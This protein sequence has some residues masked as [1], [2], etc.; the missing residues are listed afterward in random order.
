MIATLDMRRTYRVGKFNGSSPGY[1]YYAPVLCLDGRATTWD[2]GKLHRTPE[3]AAR[4]CHLGKFEQRL[5][6]I[7]TQQDI[8]I[9]DPQVAHGFTGEPLWEYHYRVDPINWA[10]GHYDGRPARIR[11]GWAHRVVLVDP[12]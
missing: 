10:I 9:I 8:A 12:S 5:E 6:Q 11:V 4:R 1:I 3:M 7:F 2:S